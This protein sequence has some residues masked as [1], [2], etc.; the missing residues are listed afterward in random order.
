MH[1]SLQILH[2]LA[3]NPPSS[4]MTPTFTQVDPGVD[5][6]TILPRAEDTPKSQASAW[7]RFRYVPSTPPGDMFAVRAGR[8]KS[9]GGEED[10]NSIVVEVEAEAEP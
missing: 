2:K 1:V 9:V 10:T 4:S 3:S 7:S 6:G 5:K 8:P